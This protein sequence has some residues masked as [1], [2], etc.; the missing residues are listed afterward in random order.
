ML[1]REKAIDLKVLIQKELENTNRS[2]PPS[3]I[4]ASHVISYGV[5][6][7]WL[8]GQLCY[9]PS[10]FKLAGQLSIVLS[11]TFSSKILK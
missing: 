7:S 11:K 10:L 4:V 5:E 1:L 2:S 3:L 8:I 6:D 9:L